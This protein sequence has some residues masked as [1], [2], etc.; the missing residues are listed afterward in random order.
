MYAVDWCQMAGRLVQDTYRIV[1]PYSIATWLDPAYRPNL[2]HC[3]HLVSLRQ[4]RFS[5]VS[6]TLEVTE[7]WVLEAPRAP[8]LLK[9]VYFPPIIRHPSTV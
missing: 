6:S 5:D 8:L 2:D 4:L 9:F 7:H 3:R 1:L